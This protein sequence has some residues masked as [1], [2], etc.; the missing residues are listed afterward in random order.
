MASLQYGVV[1]GPLRGK[2]ITTDARQ[3]HYLEKGKDPLLYVEMAGGLLFTDEGLPLMMVGG[4]TYTFMDEHRDTLLLVIHP[5][6]LPV[7]MNLETGCTSSCSL[8]V[9]HGS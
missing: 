6:F 3:V 8:A 7:V 9:N 1:N 2:A 5:N 4:S